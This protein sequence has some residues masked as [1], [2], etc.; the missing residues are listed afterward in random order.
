MKISVKKAQPH[1]YCVSINGTVHTFGTNDLKALVLETV[2]ALAPGVLPPVSNNTEIHKLA[3]RLKASKETDL[4]EF[5]LH[6]NDAKLLIFLKCTET[7]TALH[8]KLFANMSERKHTILSEDLQY[9]F[10]DGIE[11]EDL[12][13]S[14]LSLENLADKYSL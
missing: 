12:N 13:S 5:I 9:G 10:Q 1:L 4:Q 14:I 3:D 7:D 2:R 11:D 6:A 8:H